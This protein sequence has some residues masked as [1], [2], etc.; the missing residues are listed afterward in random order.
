MDLTQRLNKDGLSAAERAMGEVDTIMHV[1]AMSLYA[2]F[3]IYRYIGRFDCKV[4]T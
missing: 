4:K 3:L 1:A 2:G